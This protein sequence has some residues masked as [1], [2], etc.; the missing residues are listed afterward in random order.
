MKKVQV[1]II[2]W[3]TRAFGAE[4]GGH[5]LLEEHLEDG[6]KF[7]DLLS[8]LIARYPSFGEIVLDPTSQRL[9]EH[10]TVIVNDRFLQ[11]VGGL[12]AKLGEG[13]EVVF[14]PAFAGGNPAKA[15]L[16]QVDRICPI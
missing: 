15:G 16:A 9:Q 3:L 8:Q 10:V 5:L 7:K 13:D 4:K 1:E 6:A 12:E 2:P 14:L 11:L